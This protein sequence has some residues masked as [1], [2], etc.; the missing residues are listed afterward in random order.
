MS[1]TFVLDTCVLIHDPSAIHNFGDNHVRIPYEVLGELDRLKIESTDRG[2]SA[3]SAQRALR[4]A[5]G[6]KKMTEPSPT[7]GNG[8]IAL[9]APK[10]NGSN[11]STKTEPKALKD[12]DRLIRTV[13]GDPHL[14]ITDHKI[15]ATTARLAAENPKDTVILVTKDMGMHLKAQAADLN[16]EDYR[17]DNVNP[18]SPDIKHV[19]VRSA[20]LQIF[21]TEGALLLHEKDPRREGI[22]NGDYL[23]LE[24]TST[25][26]TM[27]AKYNDGLFSKL[28]HEGFFIPKGMTVKPLNLEQHFLIDA[29][30]DPNIDL[31]VVSGRAGT[32]KT[33]LTIGAAVAQI[34]RRNYQKCLIAKP[35]VGTDEGIGFLPGSMED[36]MRPWLQPFSD[37]LDILYSPTKDPQFADKTQSQRKQARK[38][39]QAKENNNGVAPKPQKAYDRLLNEGTLE[40]QALTFIRGRNIPNSIFILDEAQN[41]SPS[42]IK[43]LT[44]RMAKKS[45]LIMLGDTD[46]IDSPYLDKRSNGLSYT[47]SKL[48]GQPGVAV[49]QLS[50]TERSRLADLAS[51]LL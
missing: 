12:A 17:H 42:Q 51:K 39:K 18:T 31:V 26:K 15:I 32:G 50:K 38:Q 43:T 45:K 36:K 34:E 37:A 8:T 27:P 25:G 10:T 28:Q 35:I 22:E 23:L 3:R 13:T 16:V 29:I 21:A 6:N 24:A 33:L 20:E 30:M 4:D 5:F 11:K 9:L 2:R 1:K 41:T 14:A 7:K 49:V 19:K 44:T 40:I 46:Q 47:I 48:K